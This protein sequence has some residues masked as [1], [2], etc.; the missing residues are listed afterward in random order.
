MNINRLM[1]KFIQAIA[2]GLKYHDKLDT[3]VELGV[4]KGRTFSRVAPLTQKAFAVDISDKF[5]DR[6]SGIENAEL[7]NTSTTIFLNES[8]KL[9]RKFDLIFIDANH[10]FENSF[11][12][13]LLSLKVIKDGGV[14]I[15]H[16]TY[17]ASD[18]M[19]SKN[20]NVKCGTT[21]K[22]ALKIKNEFL[23]ECEIATLPF[24]HGITVVRKVCRN[25]QL[26][27]KEN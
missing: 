2:Q 6:I 13:F 15:L 8:I 7:I 25:V 5:F 18:K 27:W 21:W 10:K 20:G 4:Y 1:P 26:D 22:T 9:K 17:P 12:D 24:Y 14:I 3:Y 16:D 11:S 23:D 19:I